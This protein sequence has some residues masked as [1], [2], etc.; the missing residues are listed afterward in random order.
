MELLLLTFSIVYII[1]H[2]GIVY[3]ISKTLYTQLNK[4]KQYNG[5]IIPKPFSCSVCMT[6]WTTLIIMLCS[7]ISVIVT[8]ALASCYSIASVVI[9]RLL[10][11]LFKLIDKI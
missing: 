3:E 5:Q 10:V 6:F 1:D 7:S 11:Q 9:N 8:L 4:G 2:S